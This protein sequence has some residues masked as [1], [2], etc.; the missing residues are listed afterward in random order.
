MALPGY[1]SVKYAYV[2]V[3]DTDWSCDRDVCVLSLLTG[4][5]VSVGLLSG[6][7]L[8]IAV[9]E[10]GPIGVPENLTDVAGDCD[11]AVE[12]SPAVVTTGAYSLWSGEEATP[13]ILCE[14]GRVMSDD[15]RLIGLLTTL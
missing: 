13:R 11:R 8:A 15:V 3:C 2:S 5:G 7:D 10:S 1:E 6:S 4:V 9:V 14:P 12:P